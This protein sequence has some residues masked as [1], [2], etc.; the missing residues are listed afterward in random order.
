MM[1]KNEGEKK[2]GGWTKIKGLT[3]YSWGLET[4]ARRFTAG[5]ERSFRFSD[6][7]TD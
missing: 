1:H 7:D 2:K 3:K 4:W 5:G 6:L